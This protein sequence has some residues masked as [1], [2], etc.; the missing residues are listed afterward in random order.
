MNFPTELTIRL[1]SDTTFGTTPESSEI[2]VEISHDDLGLPRIPGQTIRGLLKSTWLTM[3]Q[4]F[5]E[6]IEPA[7]RVLGVG[8]SLD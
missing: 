7:C 4:Y 8:M 1:L 2:D 6:L 3:H 5:P